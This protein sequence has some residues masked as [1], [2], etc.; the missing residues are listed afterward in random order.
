MG[1]N[2]IIVY[3]IRISGFVCSN[4]FYIELHRLPISFLSVS[5]EKVSAIAML[6]VIASVF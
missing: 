4:K 2:K 3:L 5:Q 1:E 6:P